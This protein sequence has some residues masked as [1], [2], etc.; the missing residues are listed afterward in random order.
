MWFTVGSS[1]M[2][3]YITLSWVGVES[4]ISS[5]IYQRDTDPAQRE[6]SSHLRGFIQVHYM[7]LLM[8]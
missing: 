2:A 4:L 1:S 8:I 5:D 6:A 3:I 7:P